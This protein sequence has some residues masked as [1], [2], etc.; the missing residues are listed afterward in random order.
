MQVQDIKNRFGIIGNSPLLE[1]AIDTARQ[2]APTEISVMIMGESGV[3]IEVVPQIMLHYSPRKHGPYI[4]VNCGS[5]P[6]GTITSELFGYVKGSYPVA[7][8]SRKG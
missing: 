7:H 2:V 6:E 3:G 1:Y 8:E 4:A 5:I